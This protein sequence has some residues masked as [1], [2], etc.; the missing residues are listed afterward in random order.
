MRD[1]VHRLYALET[2]AAGHSLIHRLH[3]GVKILGALVYIVTV[4]SFNRYELGRL[5]P[6]LLYPSVIMA[7]GEI[8]PGLLIRRCALALPFCL[9]AGLSNLFLER[10]AA[11]VLGPLRISFGFLSLW[12]LLLRTLL[13]V[14]AVLI[15]AASTPMPQLAAQ[16]RRFRLPPLFV[17]LLEISYR[18][19]AVLFREAFSMYTAYAL[20]RGGTKGIDM[21]HMGTFVGCL[22]LRCTGRADR[23]YAA[24][25]CRGYSP[26]AI[27]PPRHALTPGD[28]IFLTLVCL[29]CA[30]FR[31]VDIPRLAGSW[32]SILPW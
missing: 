25:K 11:L 4:V 22:F 20:R 23:V 12:T 13:C 14:A 19:L 8:P 1:T 18:Y 29:G 27:P 7:L 30:L 24:M 5:L 6:F 17:T 26:A 28:G 15:L 9:F 2:L 31:V 16:L 3:P 32:I 10:N 21:K